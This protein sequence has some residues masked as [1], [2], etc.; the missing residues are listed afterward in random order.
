MS[1]PAALQRAHIEADDGHLGAKWHV[2]TVG[3]AVTITH[4]PVQCWISQVELTSLWRDQLVLVDSRKA[5]CII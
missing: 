5:M 4:S 2:A 1:G 3:A